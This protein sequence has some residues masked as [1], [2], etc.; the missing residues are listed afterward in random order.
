M[1][2]RHE[3]TCQILKR[4]GEETEVFTLSSK[5]TLGIGKECNILGR[6]LLTGKT[7]TALYPALLLSD[8]WYTK[9][10]APALSPFSQRYCREDAGPSSCGR[11]CKQEAL[12]HSAAGDQC[13]ATKG[14]ELWRSLGQSWALGR[15]ILL[16]PSP[17]LDP[18]EGQNTESS[19]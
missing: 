15:E 7:P 17:D 12:L 19:Q 16:G 13:R 14:T 10:S 8:T 3:V 1:S 2:L 4:P 11:T 6:R 18:S 9:P 5:P